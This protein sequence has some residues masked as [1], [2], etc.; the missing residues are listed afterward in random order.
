MEGRESVERDRDEPQNAPSWPP[1]SAD[2]G[3]DPER[4]L[5]EIRESK[6]KLGCFGVTL[7]GGWALLGM[8]GLVALGVYLL[9]R[10]DG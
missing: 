1:P 10:R 8:L 5:R 4:I 7:T 9:R 3:S 2:P 6:A